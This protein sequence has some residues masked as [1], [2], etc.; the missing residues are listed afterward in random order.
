MDRPGNNGG[1]A[2]ALSADLLV[3]G[4]AA[5]RRRTSA[6][7]PPRNLYFTPGPAFSRITA[8]WCVRLQQECEEIGLLP[9]R[10]EFFAINPL[11]QVVP[12]LETTKGVRFPT[13]L[14]ID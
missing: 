8:C 9:P 7:E 12:A 13:R 6:E 4:G 2:G 11:G 10:P 14:I 1:D 3:N 5:L